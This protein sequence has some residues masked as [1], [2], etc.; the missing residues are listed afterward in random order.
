MLGDA[1][2]YGCGANIHSGPQRAILVIPDS[3]RCERW[4]VWAWWWLEQ[5]GW[6]VGRKRARGVAGWVRAVVEYGVAVIE[7]VAVKVSGALVTLVVVVV[8][9]AEVVAVVAE[10][11]AAEVVVV[12]VVTKGVLVV[13]VMTLVAVAVVM[14][15]EVV[16]V[17]LL[18]VVVVTEVG[19]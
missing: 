6:R 17:V 3:L 18:V 13:V 15:A 2:Q 19:W 14:V 4:R 5:G 1:A 8:V 7:M 12:V 9:V 10:V 11:V 16:V